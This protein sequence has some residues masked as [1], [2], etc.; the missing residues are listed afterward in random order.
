[1]ISRREKFKLIK[2]NNFPNDLSRMV[3][4]NKK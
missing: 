2:E 1:M 4:F 3:E